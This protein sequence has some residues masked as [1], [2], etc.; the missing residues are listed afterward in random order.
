MG[1]GREGGEYQGGLMQTT[2][3]CAMHNGGIAPGKYYEINS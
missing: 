2:G 3:V 1:Q